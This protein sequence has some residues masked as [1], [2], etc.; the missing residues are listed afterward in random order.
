MV[1]E[2]YI[3]YYL[4][5]KMA[6]KR[7]RTY[8]KDEIAKKR[9]I[10][11]SK[12]LAKS[13]AA[14]NV[15]TAGF[16]GM[17]KKF[18]DTYTTST[19]IVSPTD[20]SGGEADQSSTVSACTISQGDGESNRDGRKA[21]VLSV[22]YKGIIN[23]GELQNRSGPDVYPYIFVA[24]VLDKQTNG[25]QFNSED[26]FVNPSGNASLASTPLLNLQYNSRFQVLKT[27]KIKITPTTCAHDGNL[28]QN[29]W[30]GIQE[31]FELYYEW[32]S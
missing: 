16:L 12:L 22:H 19:T 31:P 13:I 6:G 5:K 7:K 11:E 10:A 15:R 29:D 14:S 8:T 17:E 1:D 28:N 32:K 24:M 30:D 2:K 9:K 3:R 18:Y 21:Q 25:A 27:Q 26:V 20:C 23:C 4:Y